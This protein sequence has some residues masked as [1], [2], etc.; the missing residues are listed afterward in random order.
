[1]NEFIS[2]F[3]N[4]VKK[5]DQNLNLD[6]KY[7]LKTKD[8][9]EYNLKLIEKKDSDIKKKH[10]SFGPHRDDVFFFW[11]QKQIKNH[12]SQGEHKLFLALLKITEQLFLSQKTQLKS[13]KN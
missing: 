3:I 1:M 7:D 13:K 2:F 9:E 4:T 11:D 8:E 6:I 12:G 10:T 5:F